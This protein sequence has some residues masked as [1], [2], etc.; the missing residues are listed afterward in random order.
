[1]LKLIVNLSDK[2]CLDLCVQTVRLKKKD[3]LVKPF[4]NH[5][6]RVTFS[7]HGTKSNIFLWQIWSQTNKEMA[8]SDFALIRSKRHFVKKNKLIF[9]SHKRIFCH[10]VFYFFFSSSPSVLFLRVSVCLTNYSSISTIS[11]MITSWA[12]NW[13][14]KYN[15]MQ[16]QGES[17]IHCMLVLKHSLSLSHR[18][19]FSLKIQ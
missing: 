16:H 9:N 19:T 17:Q 14:G 6:R 13:E 3:V 2:R 18:V 11:A 10:L 12:V 8:Y 15:K 1:M 4:E 5:Y 7:P